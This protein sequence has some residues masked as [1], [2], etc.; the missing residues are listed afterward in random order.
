M[1]A[2]NLRGR[3]RANRYLP[4]LEKDLVGIIEPAYADS[5]EVGESRLASGL[6]KINNTTE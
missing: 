1:V 4:D 2:S 5:S 3:S 6:K